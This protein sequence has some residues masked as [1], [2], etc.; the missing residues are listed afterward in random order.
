MAFLDREDLKS[1]LLDNPEFKGYLELEPHIREAAQALF[2]AKYTVTLDILRRH[3][4]DFMVDLFLSPHVD[5]L[6]R[7]IRQR[8][9]VQAFLPYSTLELS[10]FSSL[11]STPIE[12]ITSE[13]VQLIESGKIRGRLDHPR[14]VTL[15]CDSVAHHQV[16]IARERNQQSRLFE[17]SLKMASDYI[18]SAHGLLLNFKVAQAE[19][20][21]RSRQELE[22]SKGGQGNG[23]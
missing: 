14:M 7:E 13:I 8:A 20:E 22:E 16:V 21:V 6:Y 17:G 15:D 2:T 4:S 3:R 11:F 18:K 5:I 12:E 1:R 23:Q 19:L 10:T 9:L